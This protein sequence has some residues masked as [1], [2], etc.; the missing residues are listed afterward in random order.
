[1]KFTSKKRG[2]LQIKFE[3]IKSESVKTWLSYHL[4]H[5]IMRFIVVL[6]IFEFNSQGVA[7]K[8]VSPAL[9]H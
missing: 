8:P 2:D 7:R 4:F 9:L 3:K 6:K 5:T 1:M